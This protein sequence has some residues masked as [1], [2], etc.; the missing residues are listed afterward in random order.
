MHEDERHRIREA[1]PWHEHPEGPLFCEVLRDPW[2]TVG[3]WLLEPGRIAA[4]HRVLDS[5]EVW[6]AHRGRV[7]IHLLEPGTGL[8]TL[9][10]GP[11]EREDEQPVVEVPRG[12]WQATE[13][14]P[15]EAFAYGAN[16]CAPPFR[17]EGWELAD[18]D[19]LAAEVPGHRAL[20]ERL[21][22]RR[23]AGPGPRVD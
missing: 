4:F 7:W 12:V 11:G 6:L 10:L 14:A 3:L 8:R 18:P 23:H 5:A 16:V 13:L 15:G 17:Y 20:V 9:R 1:Y 19:A 22:A 21:C 2:R